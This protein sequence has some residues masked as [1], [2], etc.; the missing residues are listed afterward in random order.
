[1]SESDISEIEDIRKEIHLIWL[2]KGVRQLMI[3]SGSGGLGG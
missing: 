2:I 1:M 3:V